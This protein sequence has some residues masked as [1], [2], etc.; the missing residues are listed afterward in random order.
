M[1]T[2][3]HA[4]LKWLP[5]KKP[6]PEPA[7]APVYQ[8]ITTGWLYPQKAEA[9]LVT[10][11]RRQLMKIIWQRTSLPV[12]LFKELYQGP[13]AHFAELAQ[14]FPASEYHHHSH[15]GG[16]LDHSLEVMAFA[17]KLRQRH[18]LPVGAAPEDQ[19]R[20]AEVWTAGILYA[21]LLHDVGKIVT[22]IEVMTDDNQHWLP[23]MEPLAQPYR[24]KYQKNR[25][26]RLHPVIGSLLALQILPVSAFN[27]LAQYRELNESFLYCISGHY[28]KAGMLG[29]LVQEADRASVSQFMGG[30]ASQTLTRPASSL[31][32]QLLS[33]LRELVRAEF[34][35]SNPSSG[36]DGWL[37]D[38]ALWLISKTT[39]DR[40]RAWLLQ[41]G[42]TSVPDSNVRLFDEM[43]AHGLIVPT[44]EGKAV[45]S[46]T[47]TADSG[48]TPGRPLTLLRLAPSRIWPNAEERPTPFTG[49]VIP[50]STATTATERGKTDSQ[51]APGITTPE[52]E[53]SELA[54]SLFAPSEQK[55]DKYILPESTDII[56]ELPEVQPGQAEP[57]IDRR[58][59]ISIQPEMPHPVA[60][61]DATHIADTGFIDWL[62][63]GIRTYKIAVNDTQARVHMVEGKAFLVSPEIF[64]LYVR[65][66]T[67]AI[68]D[69]WKQVQKAF[70]KLKLHQRGND[71]I[72]I[73]V[74]EVKGPRKTR[75]VKGYLL[76]RPEDI[77]DEAV[78]EDNP[79]LSVDS[80]MFA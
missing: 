5:R 16:L 38:D 63:E 56:D 32:E 64:K 12:A 9:L 15:P 70:Q 53:L 60:V 4:K 49:K 11:L 80:N 68:G 22:D 43:Q 48:W 42:V 79:Y 44:Q 34:K 57:E 71:G 10:P 47:V 62:R 72:N 50:G 21:A 8:E 36:S 14:Q 1:K 28:D 29:E 20:E 19:A 78:P 74:C 46:C 51:T 58:E 69:E 31:P 40:A 52:N 37:T 26:H 17:A 3:I 24:L 54:F 35:L 75:R 23:W 55:T 76:N 41:Q 7:T 6:I 59:N 13:I 18:L 2:G 65:T 27:W 39:A 77:F 73:F 66:T 61:P 30:N 33:A 45:W 25:D 67:G